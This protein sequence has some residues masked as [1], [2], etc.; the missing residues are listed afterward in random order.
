[1]E[2]RSLRSLRRHQDLLSQLA[3]REVLGRYRGSVLGLSWSFAN[4]LLML[5]VYTLVFSQV[6]KARWPGA[7]DIHGSALFALNAFAGLIIF[8]F[9][10]ECLSRSGTSITDHPNYV[11][12]VVFPL[13]VLAT[14]IVIAAMFHLLIAVLILCVFRGVVMGSIPASFVSLP[15]VLAPLVMGSLALSWLTSAITVYIRD[16]TQIISLM[17]S[18]LLFV[19]PIFYP[20]DALPKRFAIIAKL[21]PLAPII[22]QT[23]KVSVSGHWPSPLFLILSLTAS[24][25]MLEICYRI[26]TRAKRSFA[27][28]L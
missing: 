15:I 3:W 26:F 18:V 28:V 17:M 1:M 11:K 7:H 10:N 14:S 27:D 13:E 2:M 20:S 4:P 19:S 21:N 24:I 25:L 12:K 5:S 23:R 16:L 6:F 8:N 22:E 9:F